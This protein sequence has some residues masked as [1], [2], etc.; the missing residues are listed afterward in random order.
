MFKHNFKTKKIKKKYFFKK[1]IA[2]KNKY[3]II[4]FEGTI[5]YI[6]ENHMKKVINLK[7]IMIVLVSV[8]LVVVLA[9]NVFAINPDDLISD[10]A[11]EIPKD[12]YE[13][14]NTPTEVKNEQGNK[15]ID[16]GNNAT[17]N[18]ATGNNAI[19][20]KVNNTKV[21]NATNNKANL[22]QT[23]IEDYNIG[24][25]LIICVASAI[26]AYKKVSDYRNI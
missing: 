16:E 15:V 19:N 10:G 23:G 13:N 4:K 11:T 3:S 7:E 21:Y 8:V 5:I 1:S 17:G 24:I 25:L 14:A 12:E 20:T 9:T 6:K 18:N 22:P 2:K 26:Y